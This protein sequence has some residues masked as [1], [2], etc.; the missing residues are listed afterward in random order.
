MKFI[1]GVSEIVIFMTGISGN[2]FHKLPEVTLFI[3]GIPRK[4]NFPNVGKRN[5]EE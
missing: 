5:L 3:A 2:T 4:R 1:A